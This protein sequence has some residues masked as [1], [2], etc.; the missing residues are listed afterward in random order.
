MWH[1]EIFYRLAIFGFRDVIEILCITNAIYFFSI[2]LKQDQQ[3]PLVLYF[4]SMCS[5]VIMAHLA[6]LQTLTAS[7][8]TFFPVS[9][10]LFILI[11][12]KSLQKNFVT[13]KN[14]QPAQIINHDWLETLLRSCIIAA[15]NKQPIYCLIECYDK[16]AEHVHTP[17]LIK[18]KLQPDLLDA[19]L[20]STNYDR[21]K[22]IWL[23]NT[24]ELFGINT[25]WLIPKHMLDISKPNYDFDNWQTNSL[26][27]TAQTDALAFRL[28][29]NNKTFDIIA[30]GKIL[31]KITMDQ[32]IK[33]MRK[34]F[35]VKDFKRNREH[36]A[37]HNKT[38]PDQQVCS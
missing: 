38:N 22:M 34:H 32:A 27:F 35:I 36:D 7:L 1:N 23:S 30:T 13:L 12:Q 6:N 20:N 2:W 5:L 16:L 17:F 37:Y 3:K 26:L 25:D 31:E 4:Y 8:S 9:I 24:G 11:H 19:L 15:N 18:S 21:H 14:M 33:L 10:M 29:P 28:N